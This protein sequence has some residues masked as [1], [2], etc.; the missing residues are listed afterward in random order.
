MLTS[1]R[2][3][4]DKNDTKKFSFRQKISLE[5]QKKKKKLKPKKNEKIFKKPR[6]RP[7]PWVFFF[8]QN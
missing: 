7:L 8:L 5:I 3:T 1:P 2:L 6:G 4:K